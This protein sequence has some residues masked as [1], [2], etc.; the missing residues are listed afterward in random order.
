MQGMI[1]GTKDSYFWKVLYNCLIIS[2]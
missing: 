1:K 2:K